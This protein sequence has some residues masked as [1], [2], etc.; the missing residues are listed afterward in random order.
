MRPTFVPLIIA[1]L[2]ISIVTSATASEKDG[3]TIKLFRDGTPAD[4]PAAWKAI[5]ESPKANAGAIWQRR[6]GALVI[7]PGPKG[8][9]RTLRD[10]KNFTLELEWRRPE[11][12]KPGRG[13]VLI[14][15]TGK[16]KI[17]PNCLEAQLNA[18]AAGDFWGLDGYR[19]AGPSERFKQLQHDQFGTLRNLQK[20]QNAEKPPGQWNQY[21][22]VANG[23]TATLTI[24]GREVNR[25][26]GCDTV[27]GKICLTAE[28]DEIHFRKVRLT[29]LPD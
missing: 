24:N 22:I 14:R 18:D 13:G 23:E 3:Q 15:M 16:D 4:D 2:L 20:T 26:N 17:W 5:G 19:L 28:G 6:D 12:K 21:K 10:F 29:P 11:G 9:L 1:S 25:A 8:Y 27:A 7:K